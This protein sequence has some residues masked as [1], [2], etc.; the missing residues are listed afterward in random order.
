MGLD[1]LFGQAKATKSP[2]RRC[3]FKF[4]FQTCWLT[5]QF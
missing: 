2:S 5:S 3:Y 4:K 1:V